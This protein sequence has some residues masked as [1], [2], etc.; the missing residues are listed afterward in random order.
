MAVSG[1]LGFFT[2]V[3]SAAAAVMLAP[4]SAHAQLYTTYSFANTGFSW[5]TC[6]STPEGDGCYGTGSITSYGHLCAIFESAETGTTYDNKQRIYALDS[7]A[8]GKKDVVLHI[9]TKS[10]MV[11]QSG[12]AH[13]TFTPFKDLSLPL[14]GGNT[15]KCYASINRV[16]IIAG[17]SDST[18]AAY[19]QR[20]SLVVSSIGGFSPPETVTG[21]TVDAAGYIS[22]NFQDGFYLIGPDGSGLED[23]G[24]NAYLVPGG[25]ALTR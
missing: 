20:K 19:V 4:T 10:I 24:G 8:T 13:T 7:N 2:A 16:A 17:T 22:V 5:I 21:V 14:I 9:L 6:G 12:Y 25:N 11:D 18:Q 23:G 3:V 1:P 15:V